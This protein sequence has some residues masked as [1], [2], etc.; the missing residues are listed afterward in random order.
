MLAYTWLGVMYLSK[1][2]ID[3]IDPMCVGWGVIDDVTLQWHTLTAGIYKWE[4]GTPNI[5]W[6]ASLLA[7]LRYWD[8]IGGYAT[9]HRQEQILLDRVVEYIGS[10]P[11]SVRLVWPAVDQ[12]RIGVFSFV[13]E[14]NPLDVADRLADN[15]ICVR[16]GGHCAHPLVY[17]LQSQQLL[18][19][20]M[21]LYNT[22]EDIDQFF[23]YFLWKKC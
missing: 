5:I 16:V 22:V 4:A 20:S 7:S 11:D 23:A 8:R 6:A 12:E 10:L 13:L 14:E 3:T 21:Y 1:K 15:K 17:H 18:R 9:L 2:Y 19:M